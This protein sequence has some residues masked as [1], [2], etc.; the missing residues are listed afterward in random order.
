MRSFEFV[1]AMDERGVRIEGSRQYEDAQLPEY[2]T[3]GSAAA[4]FFCAEDTVVPSIWKLL[5]SNI[6]TVAGRR[7][8]VSFRKRLRDIRPVL[9]S[10]GIRA[11]MEDDEVLV[12]ENRS[13][14]PVKRG[15]VLA[16]GI[17]VIDR[18]YYGNP[19]ND[20]HIMFA[21]YN[22]HFRDVELKAGERIGQG[23]FQKVL[24]PEHGLRVKGEA[25][26]GGFGHTG[27]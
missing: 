27:R 2:Q 11:Q 22:F 8:T 4:D 5:L 25:R 9:V 20:G 15:L 3:A 19:D 24:R 13:S 14:G 21:F 23:M 26:G 1:R 18:D 7:H 6:R 16:N 10:T 17:G 12:I